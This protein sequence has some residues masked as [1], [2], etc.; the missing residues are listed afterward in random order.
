MSVENLQKRLTTERILENHLM[1]L[2]SKLDTIRNLAEATGR[3]SLIGSVSA[4]KR[5]NTDAIK[6]VR[7]SKINTL[8]ILGSIKP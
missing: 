3:S 1:L 7:R 5:A 8:K 6:S 4:L 2:N